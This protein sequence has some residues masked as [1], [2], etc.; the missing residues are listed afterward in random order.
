MPP[1]AATATKSTASPSATP[2]TIINQTAGSLDAVSSARTALAAHTAAANT[3]RASPSATPKTTTNTPADTPDARAG[4]LQ[5]VAVCPHRHHTL[6]VAVRYP[7]NDDQLDRRQ[8]GRRAGGVQLLDVA[9]RDGRETDSFGHTSVCGAGRP[10]R[11]SHKCKTSKYLSHESST[12]TRK[13]SA[14]DVWAGSTALQQV[15]LPLPNRPP[16]TC[17]SLSRRGYDRYY[18]CDDHRREVPGVEDL[19]ADANRLVR[20]LAA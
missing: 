20:S 16:M 5:L 11:A 13:S 10:R 4:D 3:R 12:C 17:M 6:V 18:S 2:A 9:R 8:P 15:R 7:H 19:F 14:T 1:P